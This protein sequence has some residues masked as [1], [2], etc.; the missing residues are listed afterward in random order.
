MSNEAPTPAP[1]P[2]SDTP[3]NDTAPSAPAD[4]NEAA[5]EELGD[6]KKRILIGSQRSDFKPQK[7]SS[8]IQETWSGLETESAKVEETPAQAASTEQV[9]AVAEPQPPHKV[10]KPAEEQ[11]SQ[12]AEAEKTESAKP[13]IESES[14]PASVEED[15]A[16]PERTPM[17]DPPRLDPFSV[18]SA[19]G[20][21]EDLQREID[22]ALGDASLNESTLDAMLVGKDVSA[23]EAELEPESKVKATVV[24]IHQ[25]NVFYNLGS[26]NEGLA[27][28][29]Q[30]DEPPELGATMEVVVRRFLPDEGIYEVNVPGASVQVSDWSDLDEG[31]VVEATITGHNSGGLEAQVNALRGFIPISQVSLYRVE[32]L[33]DFVGEKMS[34]V[35]TE[36]DP[37]RRNL[38]LSRRAVLEREKEEQ[39]RAAWEKLEVGQTHEGVVRKLMDFGAFVDIGGVDGLIHVSQL[40]WDRVNHP[41]EVLEEGQ[42]V[43]VKI[44]K[45][46]RDAQRIGLSYRDIVDNPWTKAAE[47][48]AVESVVSGTVLRLMEFG[49]FVKLEPGVEG[50]V[51]ISELAYHR[52]TRASHIVKEGDEVNVKVLSVD[53]SSQRISLSLKQTMA[54]PKAAEREKK[55]AGDDEPDGTRE[56]AVKEHKGPLKGGIGRKSGGEQFGLKW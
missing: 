3:V 15:P 5:S 23:I 31:V 42:R 17:P 55:S 18:R 49:A 45:I 38:V 40:S 4:S 43:Q 51:H 34:C 22:E 56:S 54:D 13:P 6:K 30:F 8:Q 2:N 39:R 32:T 1:E 26:R 12:P 11:D 19:G 25:D 46:D 24:K 10:S 37:D 21:S 47:K 50:L 27:S 16:A 52:V 28:L 41:S 53:P 33:E 48:Y 7:Q 36:A 35:V 29:R 44:S 14:A 20:I 9:G